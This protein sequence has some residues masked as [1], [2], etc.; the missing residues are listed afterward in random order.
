MNEEHGTKGTMNMVQDNL[1]RDLYARGIWPLRVIRQRI[2]LN[3]MLRSTAPEHIDVL[4]DA[5]DAA[6]PRAYTICRA[7]AA[8]TV[9]SRV[10]RLWE[11]WQTARQPWL[12]K[13]LHAIGRPHSAEL[14]TL[15][16][17]KLGRP[18]EIR[19]DRRAAASS[20]ALLDDDDEMVSAAVLQFAAALPNVA[21]ANDAL[22]DTWMRTG[23][24]ELERLLCGVRRAPSSPA[25]EALFLIATG[26]LRGYHEMGDDTAAYF[27]EGLALAPGPLRQRITNVVTQSADRRLIDAFASAV[28]VCRDTRTEIEVRKIAGD[29]D[30]I[31]D[32][33]RGYGVFELLGLCERWAGMDMR[34]RDPSRRRAVDRAVVSWKQVGRIMIGERVDPPDGL[35]DYFTWWEERRLDNETI[36]SGLLASDPLVR[37]GA[38]WAGHRS[39][40]LPADRVEGMSKSE[41]WP[42]RLIANLVDPQRT[43]LPNEHVWWMGQVHGE[44]ADVLL[45]ATAEGNPSQSEQ[46]RGVLS[47]CRGATD[48]TSTTNRCLAEVLL[49]FQEHFQRGAIAITADDGASEPGA[50]R[51]VGEVD[52]ANGG[53]R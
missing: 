15:S 4:V 46:L 21:W 16:L 39:G 32:A 6:H 41:H 23:S 26:D 10:D 37:A 22:F 11:R 50:I 51:I 18:T 44:I 43:C 38:A 28:S 8:E 42:E 48:Q 5:V 25:K 52:P 3:R 36:N 7:L 20:L 30:G 24:P 40:K 12:G 9:H 45:T 35:V 19:A 31:V 33:A 47:S 1:Q 29:E 14:A 34:P 27:H 49:A 13:I 53:F 17:L 2:A